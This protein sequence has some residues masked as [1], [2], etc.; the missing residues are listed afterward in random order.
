MIH[1]LSLD[2]SVSFRYRRTLAGPT[3][4]MFRNTHRDCLEASPSPIQLP[5]WAY[6]HMPFN[7]NFY[8]P[9]LDHNSCDLWMACIW[10]WLG[11]GGLWFVA[12]VPLICGWCACDLWLMCLRLSSVLMIVSGRFCDWLATY[13]CD[14][15]M[16]LCDGLTG[17]WLAGVPV[18]LAEG[19]CDWLVCL[20]L[21]ERAC[22]WLMCLCDWLVYLCDWLSGPVIGWCACDCCWVHIQL[23]N[24]MGSPE[25]GLKAPP[26][27][28]LNPGVTV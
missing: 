20:W 15:L 8:N 5:E 9:F 14:C 13:N 24:M 7:T 1:N 18:W 16:Y 4:E 12:D 21:A 10:L 22:D 25:K 6:R 11:G 23:V 17:L 3:I 28:P 19:A 27:S 26:V 2:H